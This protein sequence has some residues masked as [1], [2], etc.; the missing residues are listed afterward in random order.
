MRDKIKG[1]FTDSMWSI[2]GLMLMNV[3][4][5]FAIYPVWNRVLGSEGYGNI[6]Y[7]LSLMNIVAISVGSSCNYGRMAAS[8][9]GQTDNTS[10]MLLLCIVSVLVIPF[11]V[12]ASALS[13]ME[14]SPAETA[15][16]ALL[17]VATMWRFYGDVEYRLHLNYKGCFCYYL[18]IAIGYGIGIGL[19]LLTGLWPLALLPG[20]LLGL[21]QVWRK[22]S[23][24]RWDGRPNGVRLWPVWHAVLLLIG[25]DILSQIVFNGDRLLLKTLIG[26][27]AVTCFYLATLLGK[28]ISLVTTPLNSVIIGY[29]AR[30]QGKL[31]AKLMGRIAAIAAAIAAVGTAGCVLGSYI[32][33]PVLY[34]Q[35][36]AMAKP[37]LVLGNL[38]QVLFFTCNMLN[39]VLLRFVGPKSNV[40]SNVSYAVGFCAF[41]IPLTMWQ[42]V[43]GFSVGLL[44]SSLLRIGAA[45]MYGYFAS[46]KGEKEE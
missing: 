36:F 22:G 29:L 40:V 20:E 23:V 26:G 16:Y 14:T 39:V 31:T 35:D 25:G 8:A 18:I 7:L 15:L 37:Y 6:L 13:G 27:T 46:R 44:L 4:A 28:T 3:V 45:W 30:Y 38:A 33:L 19:F 17:A 34:P 1:F 5:Q 21:V 42:G 12:L 9:H 32:L 2:A 41:A 43:T 10:Y 11:A 24:F